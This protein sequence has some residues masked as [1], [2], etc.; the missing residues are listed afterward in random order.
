MSRT[1]EEILEF[2][3]V[4]AILRRHVTSPLGA[5]EIE[6]VMPF[7]NRADAE[8]ELACVGEAMQYLRSAERDQKQSLGAGAKAQ[9]IGFHGLHDVRNAAAKLAIEGVE[10]DPLEIFH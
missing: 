9:Q 5:A 3:E 1:A 4:T 7:R 10:L 6:N 8:A 2:R